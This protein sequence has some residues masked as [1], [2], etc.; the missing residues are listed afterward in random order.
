MGLTFENL[1]QCL[2][3]STRP[4]C[5]LEIQKEFG[6][7]QT[8]SWGLT[9][10]GSFLAALRDKHSSALLEI[11]TTHVELTARLLE[12][13]KSKY[14]DVSPKSIGGDVRDRE[15][16]GGFSRPEVCIWCGV[17]VCMVICNVGVCF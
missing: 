11:S 5:R 13:P 7:S 1:C 4:H 2:A 16:E 15:L 12:T 14:H 6:G 3:T 9:F 10:E 17:G 8:L